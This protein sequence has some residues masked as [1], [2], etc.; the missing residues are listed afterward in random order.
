MRVFE[1]A[2]GVGGRMSTRRS[3]RWQFDHGAQYFTVRDARFAR[4]VELWSRAGVVAEWQGRISVL[5]EGGR[6]RATDGSTPRFVGVPGMSAICGRLAADLDVR[7]GT[8]VCALSRSGDRWSLVTE[9]AS[10]VGE[11]DAVVLSAPARQTAAL[12]ESASSPLARRAGEVELAP[13]WAVMASFEH[14]LETGFDGA[15]VHGSPL[16]WVARDGSKPGRASH[17]SW[18]LH[19][20]PEWSRLHLDLDASEA[21]PLLLQAFAS[22]LGGRAVEPLHLAAH[23]WRFALPV[24]PLPEACLIDRDTLLVACGDWC[25][26]PR[27]EGAFLSGRAAAE[28]LLD[29]ACR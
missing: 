10:Q 27:V 25:G 22:A 11:F 3:D 15:F 23:R 8:R 12:L 7:A 21:A 1:K 9:P 17:E 16:S 13:C 2:R 24:E 5:T 28:Q 6:I 18:V 29:A 19:A 26:G 20:S 14:P 4:Q